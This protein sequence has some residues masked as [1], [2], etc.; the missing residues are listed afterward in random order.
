MAFISPALILEPQQV[1]ELPGLPLS[2]R[3]PS[4]VMGNCLHPVS[5]GRNPQLCPSYPSVFSPVFFVLSF[6]P[7][8]VSLPSFPLSSY[9]RLQFPMLFFLICLSISTIQAPG[10]SPWDYPALQPC[11]LPS[12]RPWL[13]H[14]SASAGSPVST[15]MSFPTSPT[16]PPLPPRVLH[17]RLPSVSLP[18]LP[19][20]S[21]ETSG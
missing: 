7:H 11:P 15:A 20:H 9:L 21:P 6:P 10:C 14:D 3:E 16:A 12:A 2:L 19:S 13:T 5:V 18:P 1:T 8:L 4:S 17:P